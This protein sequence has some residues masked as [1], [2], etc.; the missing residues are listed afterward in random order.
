M[1]YFAQCFKL[2]SFKQKVLEEILDS[3]S[4]PHAAQLHQ[5]EIVVR[6]QC[7]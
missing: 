2:S 7:C 6:I 4:H 1:S 3:Q 5:F